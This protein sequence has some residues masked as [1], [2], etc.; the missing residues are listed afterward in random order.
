MDLESLM[1]RETIGLSNS[2][3][4][5]LLDQEVPLEDIGDYWTIGD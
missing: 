3:R 1:E 5:I 2:N 4:E